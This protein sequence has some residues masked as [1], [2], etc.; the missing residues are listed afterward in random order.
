MP[1]Q[2]RLPSQLP[3]WVSA[4]S[5]TAAHVIELLT[6]ASDGVEELDDVED[7]RAKRVILTARRNG[8]EVLDQIGTGS[9]GD[10]CGCD[11]RGRHQ[12]AP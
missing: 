10:H 9:G 3:R 1:S 2:G 11:H 5:T 8:G 4:K 7:L 6:P 12:A